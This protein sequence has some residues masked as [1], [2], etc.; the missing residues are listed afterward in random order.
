MPNPARLESASQTAKARWIED[1]WSQAP[2]NFE[3]MNM[4]QDENGS[5]RRLHP[6]EEEQLMG[7]PRDYT[8]VLKKSQDEKHLGMSDRTQTLLGK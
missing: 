2:Y 5:Q 7:Y 8:A 4:V 6:C 1:N 3:D